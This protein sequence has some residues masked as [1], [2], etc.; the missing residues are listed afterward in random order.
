TGKV[1][2]PGTDSP[3]TVC[4]NPPSNGESAAGKRALFMDITFRFPRLRAAPGRALRLRRGAVPA[5]EHGGRKPRRRA[6]EPRQRST[7][8]GRPFD[9][10]PVDADGQCGDGVSPRVAY[11][12]RQALYVCLHFAADPGIAQL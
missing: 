6:L 3:F 11:R 8:E 5:H 2:A 12:H 1:D 4:E 9:A 7:D 10:G